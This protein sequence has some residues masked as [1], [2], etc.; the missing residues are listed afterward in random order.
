MCHAENVNCFIV[1]LRIVCEDIDIQGKIAN[2][3]RVHKNKCIDGEWQ[4]D[5]RVSKQANEQSLKHA[6]MTCINNV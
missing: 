4:T 3:R 5:E 2:N 1:V 6:L